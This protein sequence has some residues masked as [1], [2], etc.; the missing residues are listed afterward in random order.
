MEKSS[1]NF[2][3]VGKTS[4]STEAGEGY[5]RYIGLGSSYVIAVNPDA[6]KLEEIYGREMPVPDYYGEKDGVKWARVDFILKSDSEVC[7]GI[8]TIAK[9][10][11]FLR[12][13]AAINRE[14]T[15]QEAIDIY[16]NAAYGDIQDIKDK[17]PILTSNGNPAK[18]GPVYRPAFSGEANLVAF[19]KAYLVVPQALIYPNGKWEVGPDAD[20]GKF[21]LDN[22][23]DYFTGNFKEIRDAIALQPNNKVKVLYGVR[24]T[25]D[26]KQYQDICTRGDMILP[27]YSKSV[28]KLEKRLAEYKA[29]GAFPN[30][31]Y[32][33]CALQE[34]KVEASDLDAAEAS[35]SALPWE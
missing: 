13:E 28:D 19:L 22:I 2:L 34:Y 26:N 10:T 18:I 16:G 14:G 9:A 30:T 3:T 31:E 1:Y 7:N 11:F 21:G 20:N 33:V 6:K 29:S 27:N 35:S 8:E 4:E 5:K 23:K 17:K 25:D 15:R 24:T 12:N 32:K